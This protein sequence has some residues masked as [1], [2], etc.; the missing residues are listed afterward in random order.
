[1]AAA[2]CRWARFASHGRLRRSRSQSECL[3]KGHFTWKEWAAALAAE[4]A[5]AADQGESDDGSRYYDTGL[6]ALGALSGRERT[7]DHSRSS[8]HARTAGARRV[9]RATPHGVPRV[10]NF[11]PTTPP[12]PAD[13]SRRG[14]PACWRRS[15]RH[16]LGRRVVANYLERARCGGVCGADSASRRAARPAGHCC[17]ACG[18][19]SSPITSRRFDAP[20]ASDEPEAAWLGACWDWADA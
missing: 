1:M 4:V 12:G 3:E 16:A 7:G 20:R 17:S 13:R 2:R 11:S 6:R 18:M 19:R 8:A 14:V 9:R 15:T 10:S 5:P